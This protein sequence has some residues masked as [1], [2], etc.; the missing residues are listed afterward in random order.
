LLIGTPRINDT[1]SIWAFYRYHTYIRNNSFNVLHRGAALFQQYIVD[2]WLS[3]EMDRLQYYHFNQTKLRCDL[4]DT[5]RRQLLGGRDASTIGRRIVL[6]ASFPGGVRNMQKSYQDSMAIV[7][8][9]N[10]PAYFIT[11]TANPHWEE[12]DAELLTDDAGV[13]MQTWRDRPDLVA[14]VFKMKHDSMMQ[15][16]KTKSVLGECRPCFR[17][18]I[19]ETRPPPLPHFGSSSRPIHPSELTM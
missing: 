13:P 14:R 1:L 6:P 15:D 2:I 3:I 18:R 10:K 17:D 5:A 4:Y 8:T 12:I 7:R 16:L 19:P 9:F 11:F